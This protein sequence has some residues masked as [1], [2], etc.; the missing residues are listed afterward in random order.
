MF[1]ASNMPRFQVSVYRA[2]SPLVF[3]FFFLLFI[4]IRHT[5]AKHFLLTMIYKTNSFVSVY[6][7]IHQ[8]LLSVQ[9]F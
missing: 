8:N 7:M 1:C 6:D 4:V 2:I 9:I 5:A 3:C